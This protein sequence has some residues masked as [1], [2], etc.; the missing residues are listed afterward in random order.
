M[1]KGPVV[2]AKR[3]ICF[4]A[5]ASLF[6]TIFLSSEDGLCFRD[7]HFDLSNPGFSM[8]RWFIG[9]IGVFL[10][11]VHTR[12]GSVAGFDVVIFRAAGPSPW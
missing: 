9:L 5:P 2:K 3:R 1:D 7:Q 10:F 8:H 12:V 4:V 11:W 6:S